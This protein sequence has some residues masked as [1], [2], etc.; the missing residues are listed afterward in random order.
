M[1]SHDIAI[2]PW[3]TWRATESGGQTTVLID[4]ADA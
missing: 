4:I 1:P 3:L 2:E